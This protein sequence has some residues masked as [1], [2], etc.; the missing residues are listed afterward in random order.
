M[1]E[2]HDNMRNDTNLFNIF[3]TLYLNRDKYLSAKELSEKTQIPRKQ[4]TPYTNR[5]KGF[6]S[7][8]RVGVERYYKMLPSKEK[9]A[10]H[11]IRNAT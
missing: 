7:K 11:L 10:L 4:I 1:L 9:Y 2:K 8:K 5:L 6:I 3:R